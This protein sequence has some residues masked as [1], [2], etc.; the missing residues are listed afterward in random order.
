MIIASTSNGSQRQDH[1]PT[2]GGRDMEYVNLVSRIVAAEE[3]A[4]EIAREAREKQSSLDSDLK[5]DVEALREDCFAR[6]RNRVALVEKTERAAAR[7]I[8]SEW[9]AKLSR[10]MAGVE[11]ACAKDRDAWADLLFHKI[12]GE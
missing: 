2:G 5:R 11:R 8:M 12:I 6:A 3:T 4:Q 10:A 7:E 9:D 1:L